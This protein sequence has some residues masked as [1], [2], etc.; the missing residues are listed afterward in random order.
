LGNGLSIGE[1]SEHGQENGSG[2]EELHVDFGGLL[3]VCYRGSTEIL[4]PPLW[5]WSS[6]IAEQSV[7]D[8]GNSNLGDCTG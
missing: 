4:M 2:L 5:I 6:F 1:G 8:R 7:S 3:V